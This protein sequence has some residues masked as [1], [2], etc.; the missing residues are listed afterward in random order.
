MEIKVITDTQW[1]SRIELGVVKESK[2][3]IKVWLCLVA[4]AENC[5]NAEYRTFFLIGNETLARKS[6]EIPHLKRMF[7]LTLSN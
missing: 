5:Y 4:P 7:F 3:A 2:L 6:K 1:A